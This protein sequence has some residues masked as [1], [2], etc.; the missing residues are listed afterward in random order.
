[1]EK[2]VLIKDLTKY[3]EKSVTIEGHIKAIRSH[4]NV[5]FFVVGDYSSSVQSVANKDNADL[6]SKLSLETPVRVVGK[7]VERT[8]NNVRE[9]ELNGSIELKSES[10]EVLSEIDS[11]PFDLSA[12]LNIDKEFDYRPLTLRREKEKNIFLIQSKIVYA[13]REYLKENSFVEFQSP[14]IAGGDAEGGSGA[15]KVSY[16]DKDAFLTTS[17][18]LYKQ[19]LVGVFEKVFSIGN[20]FRGEKHATTRHLIEYT[21]IDFELG[22]IESEEDVMKITEDMFKYVFAYLEKNATDELNSLG[23]KNIKLPKKFPVI[24]FKEAKKVVGNVQAESE[25]D[26]S[27]AE[28]RE[29]GKWA[30][31]EH[32]SDFIFVT[33]FPLAKRPMYTMPED[34]KFSSKSF[35]LIYKGLEIA[36]GGQRLHKYK[37]ICDAIKSRGLN[38]EKFSFYLQAFK[39]GMPPH[40]GIGIGLERLTARLLNLENIKEASL[41]PREINRIDNRLS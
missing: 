25:L 3:K 37:D 8:K 36:T 35:D 26:F 22:F 6:I 5:C 10:I 24:T 14:K 31:K 1:M 40:G 29:L 7:I 38:V 32:K 12:E 4:G 41:F 9:E 27:P 18:Q 30:L 11:L 20:V 15:L 13:V 2:R 19:I 28:E 17:P 21:S 33:K 16:F 39:Y 23:I 34:D